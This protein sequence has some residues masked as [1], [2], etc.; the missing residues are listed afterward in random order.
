MI[1]A[2]G[3]KGVGEGIGIAVGVGLGVNVGGMGEDMGEDMDVG[4]IGVEEGAHP[5]NKIVSKTNARKTDPIDF[6]MTLSPFDLII[7]RSRRTNS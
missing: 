2:L 4:G 3:T 5:L 6:F 7:Q 1:I